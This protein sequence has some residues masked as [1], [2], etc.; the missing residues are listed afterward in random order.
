MDL[1]ELQELIRIFEASEL[2]EIEIE[3]GGRRVRMSKPPEHPPVAAPA[4][5]VVSQAPPP[6]PHP[7]QTPK[8]ARTDAGQE[9]QFDNGLVTIDAPVV[10]TFYASPA[11]GEPPFVLP[12][13][14]VEAEQTVCVVEA[15]KLV[16]DVS[17]KFP[18]IIEKVLVE[19]GESVEFG[20][21]LFAV[22]PLM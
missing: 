20:Q 15:M 19:N 3:E 9:T 22:R 5:M 10:G 8:I 14:T 12:G 1:T 17:A 2:F 13:D 4:A 7:E 21:P 6:I 11:P 18:A 16:N